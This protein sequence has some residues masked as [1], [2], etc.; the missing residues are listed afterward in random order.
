MTTM[1]ARRAGV[2]EQRRRSPACV[3]SEREL[4]LG[5]IIDAYNRVTERL[6]HSHDTLTVEVRRLHE[7]LKQKDEE[8]RRRERLAALGEM[9]A[10]MAHEIRNPLGGILLYAQ[11]L[12]NDTRDRPDACALAEHIAAACRKLDEI[13]ADILAFA[14]RCE[15]RLQRVS[16]VDLVGEVVELLRSVWTT[17][18]CEVAVV[19]PHAD[20]VVDADGAQLRRALLNVICNAVEAAGAGGH[21]GVALETCTDDGGFDAP[22]GLK[23]AARETR[24]EAP[25]SEPDARQ[26]VRV[27]VSDDGPGVPEQLRQR[28][29]DP[30][31]TT[32][33]SGTGLGLAIVHRIV[34]MHGGRVTVG[35]AEVGGAKFSILLPSEVRAPSGWNPNECLPS[36][37]IGPLPDGRCSGHGSGGRCPPYGSGFDSPTA[38]A[39]GHPN[40]R[41]SEEP[42][43]H[44]RGSE[45]PLPYGRGSDGALGRGFAG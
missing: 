44:G 36:R 29:F 13:V 17:T 2:E 33:D 34:E 39:M 6:K 40:G 1:M 15:L 11:M 16:V 38:K 21:V 28:I 14:D 25:D 35:E 3:V 23:S 43:P 37:E 20:I 12:E 9:A 32:K 7:Q 5:A 18:G 10:G 22:R 42:L 31:F 4:E 19:K 41:C 24:G 45:R 8:L 30:F 26:Y 27:D